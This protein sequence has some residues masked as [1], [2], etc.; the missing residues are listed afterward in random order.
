MGIPVSQANSVLESRGSRGPSATARNYF[1]L[2][3]RKEFI[4]FPIVLFP[5]AR[6]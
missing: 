5:T 4:V 3:G 2:A 6:S 1:L